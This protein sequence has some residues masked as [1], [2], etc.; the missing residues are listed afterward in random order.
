MTPTNQQIQKALNDL[1]ISASLGYDIAWPGLNFTP[2][3]SGVWLEVTFLPN[4][5]IDDG[6]ANDSDVVPQGIYQVM[7]VTRPGNGLFPVTNAAQSVI[8]ALPKGTNISG[9]V[10]VHRHPYQGSA[11]KDSDRVMI[12]V[13]IEYS[14]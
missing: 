10:R 1:L 9:L 7:A 4:R 5:G 13:T 3:E 8:D 6:L 12:P 14:S 2:P 11:I